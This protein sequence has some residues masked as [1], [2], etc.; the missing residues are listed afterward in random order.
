[1]DTTHHQGTDVVSVHN[2]PHRTPPTIEESGGLHLD[3]G[4]DLFHVSAGQAG[5][6]SPASWSHDLMSASRPCLGSGPKETHVR[7]QHEDTR[8]KLTCTWAQS[9]SVE[10]MG[11]A[12]EGSE[13]PTTSEVGNSSVTNITKHIWP[14]PGAIST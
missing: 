6:V 2:T 14:A 3:E 8:S 5:K 4:V 7:N 12:G 11:A 1:M 9:L 10:A 13:S